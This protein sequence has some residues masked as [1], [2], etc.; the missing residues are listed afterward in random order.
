MNKR[1]GKRKR[2]MADQKPN[3]TKN[4]ADN[5]EENR[6][7]SNGDAPPAKDHAPISTCK[8]SH[9]KGN[10][11]TEV[12]AF[13][14]AI[15]AFIAAI[16]GIAA[17]GFAGWQ[18]WTA[19]DTEEKQLRPYLYVIPADSSAQSQPD[20][21]IEVSLRPQVKVFGQTMAAGVNPQWELKVADFPMS[22]AFVFSYLMNSSKINAIAAP[23]EPYRMD[24]KSVVISKE[25]VAAIS[26]DKKRIYADGTVL[27]SDSFGKPRWTNFCMTTNFKRLSEDNGGFDICP[28]HNSADWNRVSK[29]APIHFHI[30]ME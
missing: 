17:A 26:A 10:R 30:P 22:N 12:L 23:N 9:D 19:N 18:G 21:S 27:Y 6:R 20:G 14:A 4:G 3:D 25:D 24:Q 11:K 7:S 16:G 8:S 28:I 13:V 15:G 1:R 5:A 29:D 2:R